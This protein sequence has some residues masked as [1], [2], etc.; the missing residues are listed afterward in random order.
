MEGM[1]ASGSKGVCV[2]GRA[3]FLPGRAKRTSTLSF[4]IAAF[5]M[6]LVCYTAEH[7][8]QRQ[9]APLS[10]QPTDWLSNIWNFNYQHKTF[11]F[12]NLLLLCTMLRWLQRSQDNLPGASVSFHHGSWGLNPGLLTSACTSSAILQVPFCLL[13]TEVIR[14]C[15]AMAGL[16]SQAQES[17]EIMRLLCS[18]LAGEN[19]NTLCPNVK[20]PT[21]DKY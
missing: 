11:W 7:Q 8:K 19:I 21:K 3:G 20:M 14:Y 2:E 9:T 17:E 1:G 16:S 18:L 4:S 10:N 12:I 13:L 5:W 15:K 6:K